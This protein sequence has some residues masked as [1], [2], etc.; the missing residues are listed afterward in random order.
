MDPGAQ[1]G[2]TQALGLLW[3][4]FLPQIEERVGILEAA[5]AALAEAR[6]STE[7]QETAAAAAHKLAGVLGTFGLAEGTELARELE[8]AY[9]SPDGVAPEHAPRLGLLAAELRALVQSRI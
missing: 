5:A 7:E 8:T 4:R 2:L 3:T 6:L 1:P 9:A